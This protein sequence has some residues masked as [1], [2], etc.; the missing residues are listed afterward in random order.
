MLL[1]IMT[2]RDITEVKSC[3]QCPALDKLKVKINVTHQFIFLFGRS[4]PL[5][6]VFAAFLIRRGRLLGR[7]PADIL[8]RFRII[9]FIA[10]PNII[11]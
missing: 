8:M 4:V 2:S 9:F 3:A 5:R 1:Q 6:D 7:I 10:T 11:N